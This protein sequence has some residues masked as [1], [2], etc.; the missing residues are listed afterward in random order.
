M[1]GTSSSHQVSVSDAS[2]EKGAVGD[3]DDGDAE[4]V[5]GAGGGDRVPA[6]AG[7]VEDDR[8]VLRPGVAQV[9]A[10]RVLVDQADPRP[11]HREAGEER[12]GPCSGGLAG[13]DPH[14]FRL[15][16]GIGEGRQAVAL[17]GPEHGRERSLQRGPGRL[18]GA[19]GVPDPFRRA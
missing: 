3:G 17:D 11:D 19:V 9:L 14:A 4:A 5:E 10:A 13:E 18:D 8:D 6:V 15:H 2:G 7:E 1:A 16:Q 12:E